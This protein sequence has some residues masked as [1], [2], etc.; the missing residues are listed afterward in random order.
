ME[1]AIIMT[2]IYFKKIFLLA[3]GSIGLKFSQMAVACLAY[4]TPIKHLL[5]LIILATT[6]DVISGLFKAWKTKTKIT[7][8]RLRDTIF[9]LFLYLGLMLIM[10]GIELT[11]VPFIPIANIVAGS[12]LFIEAYSIAEN[13]NIITNGKAN[14]TGILKLIKKKF[15]SWV[16]KETKED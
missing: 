2:I 4:F 6:L 14:L 12:I 5:A 7:S 10:F 16:T 15:T 8:N 1:K 3:S 13:L 9:K 11:I